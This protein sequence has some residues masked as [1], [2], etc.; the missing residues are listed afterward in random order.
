MMEIKPVLPAHLDGN[1]TLHRHHLHQQPALLEN[2]DPLSSRSVLDADLCYVTQNQRYVRSKN[3]LS[4]C[5]ECNYP[6]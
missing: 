1:Q 3:A 6:L 2:R 4:S 5:T